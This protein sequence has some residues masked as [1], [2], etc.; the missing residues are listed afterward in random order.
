MISNITRHSR[1]LVFVGLW[2]TIFSSRSTWNLHQR[3]SAR[4]GF[5]ANMLPLSR[6]SNQ[7]TALPARLQFFLRWRRGCPACRA[8]I[9]TGSR[10]RS[11]ICRL[12]DRQV[13]SMCR[14]RQSFLHL[15]GTVPW[16]HGCWS[17][18]LS[19]WLTALSRVEWSAGSQSVT[20]LFLAF[21][22]KEIASPLL[23]HADR[24]V[25][26]TAFLLAAE[27]HRIWLTAHSQAP[28]NI[29]CKPFMIA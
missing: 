26:Y 16:R 12:T 20:C 8:C 18:V 6:M 19:L 17:R 2:S 1:C 10:G 22:D 25:M 11:K 24:M 27:V 9:P 21:M 3:R 13:T 23:S 29:C 14:S 4:S 5:Q 15:R 7:T 28:F